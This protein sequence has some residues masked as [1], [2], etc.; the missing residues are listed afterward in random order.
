MRSRSGNGQCGHVRASKIE[1]MG[2]L[3]NLTREVLDRAR[4]SRDARF[5]GKF[6]IA[7]TST[8]IYCR[9]VCPARTSKDCNVRYYATAAEASEAGFR[10]C[11]RCRPEA[12]PGSPAW[13][14]TSAVVRRALRLI[15]E[16]ALEAARLMSLPIGSA[17]EDATSLGCLRSTWVPRQRPSRTPAACI[18]RNACWT[19]RTW[20]LPTSR[21]HPVSAASADS[22]MPFSPVTDA[23]RL[24]FENFDP[25]TARAMTQALCCGSP[26]DLLMIG[27]TSLPFSRNERSPAWKSSR[28]QTT[29]AQFAPRAVMR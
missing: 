1:L 21:W 7:V 8:K 19:T 15:Q 24:R 5:D 17:L 9:P 3:L 25:Q 16:G 4:A 26:T 12:A 11:L 28:T 14:G 20:P 23:H 27:H 2:E 22:M 29:G 18:L 13:V 10:P 6:F